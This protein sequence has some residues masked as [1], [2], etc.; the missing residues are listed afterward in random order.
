MTGNPRLTMENLP[1]VV[2]LSENWEGSMADMSISAKTLETRKEILSL[3]RRVGETDC[4]A[5]LRHSC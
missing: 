3:E 4:S 5:K 2:N 1:N